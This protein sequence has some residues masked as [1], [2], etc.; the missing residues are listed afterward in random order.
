MRRFFPKIRHFL[1]IAAAF[2]GLGNAMLARAET[3]W[4]PN[5]DDAVLFDVRLGQFRLGEGVRGYQT[6]YGTCVDFADTIMALDLPIRLDK[7]LRRA[8]GWVFAENQN[9]VVDRENNTVQ[10]VNRI[11][12]LATG[13]VFDAPEGWCID[14][15]VLGAWLGDLCFTYFSWRQGH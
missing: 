5:S 7:K 4:K 14:S 3:T 11:E 8:T 12:K 9:L 10:I 15:K 2:F 13:Q 1:A 6:P